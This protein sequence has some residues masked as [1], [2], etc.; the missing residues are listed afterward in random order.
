ML[1]EKARTATLDLF[2]SKTDATKIAS[3]SAAAIVATSYYVLIATERP[4]KSENKRK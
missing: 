3:A 1:P 4:G 2:V